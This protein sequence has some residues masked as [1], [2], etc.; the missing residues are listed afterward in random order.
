MR[1]DRGLLG[2][3]VFLVVAGAIALAVQSGS[4]PDRSWWTFWPLNLVGAGVGR[5]FQRTRL[6]PLGGL[7]MAMTGAIEVNAGSVRLCAPTDVALRLRVGDSVLAS[8]DFADAGL[9]EVDGVWE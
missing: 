8:Q 9:V 4:I 6:Q 2:W 3:G 1:T 5:I 7:V